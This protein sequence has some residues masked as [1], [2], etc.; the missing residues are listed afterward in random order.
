VCL[1]DVDAAIGAEQVALVCGRISPA[2]AT[3]RNPRRGPCPGWR[4]WLGAQAFLHHLRGL[5]C[6]VPFSAPHLRS[7]RVGGS[8]GGSGCAAAQ[9]VVYL[10]LGA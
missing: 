1:L 3:A 6:C 4:P 9:L 8:A 7:H 10:L 2:Y 5:S